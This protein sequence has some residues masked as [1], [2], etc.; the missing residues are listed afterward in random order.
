MT[1]RLVC[2][3]EVRTYSTGTVVLSSPLVCIVVVVRLV[4]YLCS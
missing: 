1:V 3:S 2:I 4:S